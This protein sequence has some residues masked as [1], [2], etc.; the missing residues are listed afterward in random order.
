M[1]KIMNQLLIAGVVALSITGV[2][3]AET[4]LRPFEDLAKRHEQQAPKPGGTPPKAGT[5][6]KPGP[7]SGCV[8]RPG[9]IAT[10]TTSP[11]PGPEQVGATPS[12]RAKENARR[13]SCQ[14]N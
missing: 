6:A 12:A 13:S 1:A 8:L 10:G 5:A 7:K 14:S 9:Q 2:A 11:Q 4:G 3:V